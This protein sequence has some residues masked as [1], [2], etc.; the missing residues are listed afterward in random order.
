MGKT[1]CQTTNVLLAVCFAAAGSI[2][3]A[4]GYVTEKK[5]HNRINEQNRELSMSI[6]SASGD[7]D[8]ILQGRGHNKSKSNNSSTSTKSFITSKLWCTGFGIYFIGSILQAAA[9]KFGAQSVV[10]PLG[11]LTLVANTILATKYLGEPFNCNDILGTI[12]IIIGSILAVV[13][14]P[15]DECTT[16]SI[17]DLQEDYVKGT[18]LSFFIVWSGLTLFDFM[19]TKYLEYI[20]NI[21]A[22]PVYKNVQ[23]VIPIEHSKPRSID[24][25]PELQSDIGSSATGNDINLSKRKQ[26]FLMISYLYISSYFGSYN[27]VLMKSIVIIIYS[28]NVDYFLNWFFWAVCLAI[29][30]DNFLMEYFKQR[31]LKYFGAL[32]VI[33]IYQVLLVI[34]SIL[35]GAMYFDEFKDMEGSEIALFALA[36]FIILLG[37]GLMALNFGSDKKKILSKNKDRGNNDLTEA[38]LSP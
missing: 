4:I 7:T 6:G 28:F 9:L 11:S 22:P 25:T 16:P 18:F 2:V 27:V 34:G 30:I 12:L 35:M 23:Q 24:Y 38:M 29:A 14:G 32:L 17:H 33:P 13:F 1:D 3:S 36:I 31:A 15:R 19:G 37:I 5:A 21:N 26:L 8:E 10:T 20:S